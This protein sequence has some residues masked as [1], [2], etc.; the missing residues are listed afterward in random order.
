MCSAVAFFSTTLGV[1]YVW[2]NPFSGP[3]GVCLCRVYLGTV[4]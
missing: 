4:S 3:V 2:N 1:Q